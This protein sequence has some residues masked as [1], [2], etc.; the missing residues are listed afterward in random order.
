MK[1]IRVRFAPSPTGLLHIGGAR[2]ALFN[3]LFTRHNGGSFIIRIEDTDRERSSREFED[4]LLDD[5]R[6]LG[7]SWDEGPEAGGEYGPYRQTERV[8]IYREYALRLV[9][10]G[11]AFPCFCTD[12]QLA[13]KRAMMREDGNPPQYD[14]TCRRLDEAARK[15]KRDQGL[16]E[17]IRFEVEAG[18]DR[19]IDDIAR[20]EVSFP[21]GMVGDFVILRSNGLPTYNFAAAIDDALMKITHVIRGAEHLSNTLRQIMIYEALELSPPRFA[22]IPLILGQDRT[23]LSKRHGA[24]NIRDYREKGYPAEALLNYLAFLGWATRGEKEILS[25]QELVDEFELARVSDSP[26]I[27]DEA[28][29]NWVTSRHVRAGGAEKYFNDAKSF[30]PERFRE[31]YS[32]EELKTIFEISSENLSSF[33]R[34]PFE[35]AA[36]EPGGIDYDEEAL[37]QLNGAGRLLLELKGRFEAAE[38]WNAEEI[39]RIIKETGRDLQIKGKDLYMPLRV[40]VTGVSHGPDLVMV[41]LIRGKEDVAAALVRAAVDT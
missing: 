7:L 41:I 38:D 16:P 26:S 40:A 1:D 11:R 21:A 18:V 9:E 30:F 25:V 8:E 14:G 17:S 27:F 19:K 3:W 31:R 29:L 4:S 35:A 39:R 28:K 37:V 32:E 20:G 10:S 2:T 36:F 23:K 12:D 34:L 6:W 22:H 24:P 13:E 5:L 15:E 33:D